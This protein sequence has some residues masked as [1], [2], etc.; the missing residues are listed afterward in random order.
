MDG[1]AA[2]I[3]VAGGRSSRFGADKLQ[4]RIG[5][6]TLLERTVDA[7][8]ACAPVVLVGAVDAPP[9]VAVGVSEWPRWG[10][11]C[12]AIAAGVEAVPGI[13]GDALIV[14]AD[15]ADPVAALSALL[16]LEAGVLT[17]GGRPQW[18]LARA[19]L[20]ALR[21]RLDALRADR[22]TLAGASA[23]A[24]VDVVEARHAVDPQVC[25]DIDTPSDLPHALPFAADPTREL[26]HGTV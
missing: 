23:A 10:G 21:A 12:A 18:L 20:A 3:V 22:P 2:V 24:L 5:G 15:L 11:P 14:S 19:P 8:G 13:E 4:H 6:R 25:A 16:A 1:V 7:A 9:G 17:A 26:I